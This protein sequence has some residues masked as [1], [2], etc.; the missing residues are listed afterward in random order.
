LKPSTVKSPTEFIAMMAG[1]MSLNA[2]A[3]DIMLPALPF[4][5]DDL[6]VADPNHRQYVIIAYVLGLGVAQLFFGPMSDRFGRRRP[7]VVSL[8]GYSVFGIVCVFAPS[9]EVLVAARALQGVAASGARVISMSIIRDKYTGRQMARIMSLTMMVFMA[10][11]ML[12]PNLGMLVLLVAPWRWVFVVLG[13]FGVAMALWVGVRLAET[14][15]PDRRRPLDPMALGSAYALV[16]KTRITLGYMIAMGVVF[17]ALF[18]FISSSEQ[19]YSEVFDR[20]ESFTLYF[21]TVAGGMAFASFLNAR[22]VERWGMRRLAHTALVAFVLINLTSVIAARAGVNGFAAFHASMMAN[23]FC[24][25]FIGANFNALAM[26]PLGEIAGTASAALGFASTSISG[27]LGAAVGQQFDGTSTPL[28]VGFLAL[29][30]SA[31]A[32]VTVT[33]RGRLFTSPA[34]AVSLR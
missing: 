24:F 33:E 32:V 20:R 31:L 7:L 19:L 5:G 17:G 1:L 15:P 12:A 30:V 3:I 14:L 10:M 8:V 21:A 29:G 22:L 34:P 9:F 6:G 2:L 23:F 28:I 25:S 11:P 27:L 4:M 18:A 16:F 13:L 26:E